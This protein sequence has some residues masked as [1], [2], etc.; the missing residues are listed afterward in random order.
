VV[1]DD[2]VE[3]GDLAD[4]VDAGDKEPMSALVLFA[5]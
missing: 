3:A 1:L 5:K 4:L 2:F